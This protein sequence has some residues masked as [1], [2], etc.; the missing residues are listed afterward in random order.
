MSGFSALLE[1]KLINIKMWLKCANQ[2]LR[3]AL[4]NLEHSFVDIQCHSDNRT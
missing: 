4:T 3:R 1:I 2:N